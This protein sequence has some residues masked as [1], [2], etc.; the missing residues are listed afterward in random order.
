MILVIRCGV[1]DVINQFVSFYNEAF[2]FR[3]CENVISSLCNDVINKKLK[4]IILKL[5]D[6]F[7]LLT[8]MCFSYT[9]F[10]HVSDLEASVEKWKLHWITSK[11]QTWVSSEGLINYKFAVFVFSSFP[12]F[13]CVGVCACTCKAVRLHWAGLH[14]STSVVSGHVFTRPELFNSDAWERETHLGL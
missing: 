11:L 1:A 7:F 14:V 5:A 6:R 13:N 4:E 12:P 10:Y 8:V 3:N 9:S 2:F